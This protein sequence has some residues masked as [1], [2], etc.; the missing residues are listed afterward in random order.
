MHIT[1]SVT[2]TTTNNQSDGACENHRDNGGFKSKVTSVEHHIEHDLNI[3]SPVISFRHSDFY[4]NAQTYS[5]VRSKDWFRS[6]T[7]HPNRMH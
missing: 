1:P 5:W 6:A 2:I 3:K 7:Q 4:Y